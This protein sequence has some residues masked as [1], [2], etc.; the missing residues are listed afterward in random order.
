MSFDTIRGKG[1]TQNNHILLRTKN[2]CEKGID[3]FHPKKMTQF[4]GTW[5][6]GGAWW[7]GGGGAW[8]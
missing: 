2:T 8:W 5:C 1:E 6:G 3:E 7:C 4:E